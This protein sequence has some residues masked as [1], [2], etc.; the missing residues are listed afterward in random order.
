MAALPSPSS[1][2]DRL[3]RLLT[4]L[5]SL[6]PKSIDLSLERIERLLE[7]LGRPQ[8]RLPPVI[9]IAGTNGK[10]STAA[11]CRSILEAAGRKVH[12]YTSP[13]LVRFNERIRLAGR[14]IDDDRL[15]AALEECEKVNDG[16]PITFFEITTAAALTLFSDEPADALVL[17]VGLGG[18]LDTTN[19]IASPAVSVITPVGLD[20][21]TF[22][23]NTLEKI[24]FEKAGI[25]KRNRPAIIA[26]QEE[27]ALAVIERQASKMRSPMRISGQHWTAAEE[28]GRLI[29]HH[30]AGLIDLPAPRLVGRHQFENAGAAVMAVREM[31][32][33]IGMAALETGIARAEWPARL[34]R[35]AS[36]ALVR[37]L[38]EGAELWLD[39]GHNP[40]AGQ[41]LATALA[42]LEERAPKPLILISGMLSTKDA[43]GFFRP[44]AGLARSVFT[45]AIE[46]EA[47]SVSAED[48]A[49][50]AS[51]AG[52]ASQACAGLDD[53][54]TRALASDTAPRILICGSLYLAGRVL[55]RN[56]TPPA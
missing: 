31:L 48:L 32:P 40:H 55:A 6:H 2:Q 37:D 16:E 33:D 47:L 29:V 13:H 43:S 28:S 11:F 46:D 9:H 14:L 51:A 5:L 20:H 23:G 38:P 36:G 8:D 15:I 19:V 21:Q 7:R 53:A 18:R 56:G 4:R 50:M 35:L 39:G 45:L 17:E 24:A 54:M 30:E 42:D 26:R 22:L 27:A 44:F 41:A 49:R 52:L 1:P 25:L 3:G 34:Q 10:G 12:V